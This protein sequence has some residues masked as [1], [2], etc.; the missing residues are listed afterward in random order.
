MENTTVEQIPALVGEIYAKLPDN[1]VQEYFKDAWTYMTDNYTKFQ[2]ATWGSLLLHE[3]NY[4]LDKKW[5]QV[6]I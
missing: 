2:I 6:K 1:P 3:V 4:D 5:Y